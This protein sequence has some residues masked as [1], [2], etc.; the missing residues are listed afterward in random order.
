MKARN[1]VVAVVAAFGLLFVAQMPSWANNP[2]P[3]SN[4]P[5][6]A[7][8]I[9]DLNGT[10][11]PGGGNN[12]YQGYSVNFTGAVTSTDLTFALREDP[13]FL[14]L[15]NVSVVDNTT[16]SGNLV[17]NGNFASG[18]YGTSTA[19]DWTYDNIFGA[20]F[21][22]LVANTTVPT[23]N[24]V[25]APS[26]ITT[27]WLD[28][29]VQAY[30]AIDQHIATNIGDSYTI[31][32]MLADNS[33]C[34]TVPVGSPCNFRDLS[35]N[36]NSTTTGGDGIDLTVYAQN[37]LPPPGTPEPS[38]LLMFGTGLLTIGGIVRRRLSL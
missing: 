22:G 10:P 11:I 5:P 19:T 36:G 7:G 29:A 23:S 34:A 1:F 24:G 2:D 18:I 32:F 16:L 27:C 8:A 13:A 14:S 17:L 25:C 3:G 4:T 6:P 15:T 30:D 9:L 31:S 26:V 28:G 33:G 37:G 35:T 20:T 38:T 12:T 21:G